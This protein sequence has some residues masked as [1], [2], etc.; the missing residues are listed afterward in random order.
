MKTFDI[1]INC[2][3][4]VLDEKGKT[5]KS[6]IQEIN[7]DYM[8]IDIPMENGE[9]L[10]LRKN[11]EIGIIIYNEKIGMLYKGKLRI[12]DKKVEGNLRLYKVSRPYDIEKLQRRNYVRVD[13]TRAVKYKKKGDKAYS[14]AV[15]LDLSGG[16][17]KIKL[18]KKVEVNDIVDLIAELDG[19]FA[20]IRGEVRRVYKDEKDRKYI[21]GYE[22]TEIN[23]AVRDRII[24]MVFSIMRRQME[25]L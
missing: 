10:L 6:R 5:Y 23:E 17:M 15:I 3:L 13:T 4:D 25:V 18:D 8:C 21:I 7:E 12:I 11:C 1:Y 16:G 2:I 9:Y 24:H 22:F 19:K 20:Q 14:D